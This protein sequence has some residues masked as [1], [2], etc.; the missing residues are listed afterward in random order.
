MKLSLAILLNV[1]LLLL[2]LPWLRRQWRQ[3]PSLQWRLVFGLGLGLRVLV[4]LV[5]DWTPKLDAQFMSYIGRLVTRQLWADPVAGLHKLV[6]PVAVFRIIGPNQNYDAVYQN[7]SN[8]WFLAKILALLNFASTDIGWINGLYLSVLSFVGCW[9]LVRK[10]AEVFPKTPSG[11]GAAAFLLWPSVWYWGS[12]I[13]KEAVLLGS[14]AWLTA[15]VLSFLYST[16]IERSLPLRGGPVWWL[17]TALLALVH[18]QMRYF[19]AAPLLGVLLAIG[20]CRG[21]QRLRVVRSR[22]A[23]LLAVATVLGAGVWVASQVSVAF[24]MNKFTNQVIQVYSFEVAHSQGRP[25]FEYPNLRPTIESIAQHAPVAMLNTLSRP[26]LGESRQLL[27]VAVGLENAALM[28]LLLLALVA[29]VLG[30]GGRLP[31]EVGLGLAVFCMILAVLMGLTTPNLGSLHRYRISMLPYLLLL[32]L[33]N[34]Y[35]AAFFQKL[36]LGNGPGTA[37]S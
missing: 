19:F 32:L 16:P 30:R 1:L 22:L 35:A 10:L 20:V 33:Q 26:W 31:F 7:T 29:L 6:A 13:S 36:G 23:I 9:C 8:T 24:R 2:V 25:H 28:A 34:D 21:G 37:N 3:L 4:T 5:R 17:G 27:Y 11:A 15:Q 14:G 12:G 18:F